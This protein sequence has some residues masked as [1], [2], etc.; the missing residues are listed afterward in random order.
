MKHRTGRPP[1]GK[2]KSMALMA[3]VHPLV[4]AWVE[5]R[6]GLGKDYQ[7]VSHALTVALLQMM[8]EKDPEGLELIEE[9]LQA[10]PG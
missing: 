9:A 7:T 5:S 10:R 2:D 8:R 3:Y 1:K 6:C 4:A